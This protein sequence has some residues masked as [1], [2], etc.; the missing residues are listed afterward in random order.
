MP[1][2][3]GRGSAAIYVDNKYYKTISTYHSGSNVNGVINY[4]FLLSGKNIH[5]VKVVNL[6]TAGHPRIDV[7]AVIN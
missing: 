1:E 2:G 5:V 3:P 4:Q 7:D 6:A